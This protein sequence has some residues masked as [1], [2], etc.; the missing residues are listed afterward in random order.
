MARKAKPLTEKQARINKFGEVFT[1]MDLVDRMLDQLPPDVWIDPTETFCDPCVG[2]GNFI[3]G[4]VPRLMKGLETFEP[5]P[6]KRYKWI[7]ERMIYAIEIQQ[8]LVDECIERFSLQHIRHHFVCADA[9]SYHMR[10]DEWDS[11]LFN[12]LWT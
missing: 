11:E 2:N 10:F 5:D 1:P 9:L 7:F 3:A 12:L 4:I 8:R 6:E